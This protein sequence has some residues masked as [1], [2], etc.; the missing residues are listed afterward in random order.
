MAEISLVCALATGAQ[1]TPECLLFLVVLKQIIRCFS[2]RVAVA[3]DMGFGTPVFSLRGC[4]G[5]GGLSATLLY[6]H[7][8]Y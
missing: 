4:V 6:P 3:A 1:F 7:G 5:V 2:L 8:L